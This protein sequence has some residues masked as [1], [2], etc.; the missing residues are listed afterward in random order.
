M[1]KLSVGDRVELHPARDA[2][3]QGDRFG[4]VEYV[5]RRI[6]KVRMDRSN[7]LLSEHIGSDLASTRIGE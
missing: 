5:G 7:R 1:D 3:M 2:W 6:V 4:T